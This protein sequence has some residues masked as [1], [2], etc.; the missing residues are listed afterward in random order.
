M[1]AR[2]AAEVRREWAP[3]MGHKALQ[4]VAEEIDEEY[5]EEVVQEVLRQADIWRARQRPQ[6]MEGRPFRDR[7]TALLRRWSRKAIRACGQTVPQGWWQAESQHVVTDRRGRY[8]VYRGL[9]SVGRWPRKASYL[10]GVED[11]QLWAV[12][13][14]SRIRTVAEALEWVVPA[15]ARRPGT[16]RQGDVFLVP[17]RV[18]RLEDLPQNHEVRVLD[19]GS[20]IVEHPQHPP[21]VLPPGTRWRVVLRK[22]VGDVVAGD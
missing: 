13:I 5:R 3:W 9:Y 22:S 6:Q 19:D 1:I 18:D 16:I 21:V 2:I 4:E 20:R 17:S 10:C 8:W 7:L 14:P 11:G 12:R 15:A